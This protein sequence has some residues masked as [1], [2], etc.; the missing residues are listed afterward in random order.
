MNGLRYSHLPPY[1]DHDDQL[2]GRAKQNKHNQSLR[3][4]MK[5]GNLS[6]TPK[7]LYELISQALTLSQEKQTQVGYSCRCEC[8]SSTPNLCTSSHSVNGRAK[9]NKHMKQVGFVNVKGGLSSTPKPL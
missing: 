3:I 1:M 2:Q 7:L 5:L 6:S 8:N 4:I 9:E